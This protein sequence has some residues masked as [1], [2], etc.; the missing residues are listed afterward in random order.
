MNIQ[1]SSTVQLRPPTF[2]SPH[3]WT[4]E[5]L[6]TRRR[7]ALSNSGVLL[8]IACLQQQEDTDLIAD[9]AERLG[10]SEPAV[11][12]TVDTLLRHKLLTS[13]TDNMPQWHAEL[14]RRWAAKGWLASADYHV[15]T[16]DYT[17]LGGV[18]EDR[19]ATRQRMQ[20]YGLVEE[21]K[22]R[23][24]CYPNALRTI[25]LAPLEASQ[26]DMPISAVLTRSATTEPLASEQLCRILAMAFGQVGHYRINWQGE[27]AVRR[28]TPSGGSRHPTEAY[29]TVV[30]VPGLEPGWY[31][32][33][34]SP[35]ALELLQAGDV[36]TETL[37]TQFP[38]TVGRAPFPVRAIVIL[39]TLF[40]RN[41]YRY[42]E[43]RTFRTIHMDAG[44]LAGTVQAAAAACSARSFVQYGADEEAIERRLRLHFLE[45][46]YQLSIAL[47]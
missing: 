19:I 42:R 38:L 1:T 37:R 35:P 7:F 46:G 29:V 4:A 25:P 18:Q 28:T 47:G 30:D 15:A 9:V 8:L 34:T 13:T 32:F 41:M 43:P 31:H 6:A 22:N 40:E 21:D 27:P 2:I 39:T 36:D 23:Y 44:H 33:V 14:R 10:L 17:F 16:Y 12:R 5:D 11:A 45:E 20:G 24:K 3:R 26:L